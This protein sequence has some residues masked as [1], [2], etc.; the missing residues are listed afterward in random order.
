MSTHAYH[1]G[2]ARYDERNVWH[3]GCPECERRADAGLPGVLLLDTDNLRQLWHDA[4]NA[5]GAQGRSPDRELSQC[6][7]K[8][9]Q[10]IYHASVLVGRAIG[11]RMTPSL[12]DAKEN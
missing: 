12:A 4:L 2:L 3:D 6:D 11:A 10:T 5:H 9:M 7:A 8:A 1:N